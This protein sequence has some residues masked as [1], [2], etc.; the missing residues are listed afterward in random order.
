LTPDTY[1]K[2]YGADAF[3]AGL[4]ALHLT[5]MA[6]L[7]AGKSGPLKKKAF[8]SV[9]GI[10]LWAGYSISQEVSLATV[11]LRIILTS[12]LCEGARSG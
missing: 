6:L 1:F 9:A 5:V 4:N 10:F 7:E 11:I 8:G 2:A 12:E 3:D